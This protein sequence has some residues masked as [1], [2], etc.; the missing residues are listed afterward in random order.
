MSLKPSKYKNAKPFKAFIQQT[1]PT[2]YDDSLSYSELLYKVLYNMNLLV[3]N[4][5]LLISDI[6]KLYEYTND[7]FE[8]L[9]VQTE[10]DN[11]LEQMYTSGQLDELF[12]KYLD[13]EIDKINTAINDNFDE[14]N[15]K[16]AVLESRM[17]TFSSLP[18]GSTAGD[19]EL[20]DIRVGYDGTTYPNA[21]D[22]V[23]TQI[24]NL[25]NKF[26]PLNVVKNNFINTGW[27]NANNGGY[28]NTPTGFKSTDFI[29]IKDYKKIM[30]SNCCS[31]DIDGIAF[32]DETKNFIKGV[33]KTDFNGK[34]FLILDIEYYYY[35][36]KMGCKEENI[37]KQFLFLSYFDFNIDNVIENY[38]VDDIL[39]NSLKGIDNCS[40]WMDLNGITFKDGYIE[41]RQ[42]QS[43]VK[44]GVRTPELFAS[45]VSNFATIYYDLRNITGVYHIDFVYIKKSDNRAIHKTLKIIS[46]DESG[47]LS[48]D[49]SHYSVYND[50]DDSKPFFFLVVND[51]VSS[52]DVYTFKAKLNPFNGVNIAKENLTK[53]I[54]AI[55]NNLDT[56]ADKNEKMS[57]NGVLVSGS[58]KRFTPIISDN[59]IVQYVPVI[60]DN[61]LFIGNSLLLGFSTFGMCAKN[62]NHDY[63][64]Y[65]TEYIKD[66]NASLVSEKLAGNTFEGATSMSAVNNWYTSTLDAKL[67]DDIKLVVV[68][69]GDNV[70]TPETLNNFKISCEN[71]LTHIRTNCPN[72]RVC[73]VG[74][75][76]GSSEKQGI[77]N[78][79]CKQTGCVFIDISDLNTT[80]NQA[81]IGDVVDKGDGTQYIVDSAGIA[82]HPGN[83]GMRLI[84][85]RIL[86]QLD[87][88][89]N[90][91]AFD[92]SYDE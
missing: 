35:Y 49:L 44:N 41:Y 90:E 45:N 18:S 46:N 76:Y 4:N 10:I 19:A 40:Y 42:P 57:N 63:Y 20:Q 48:V 50:F 31:Y 56:K 53:T 62:S 8:N 33:K 21:G 83:K 34:S 79:A 88:S 87:I 59:G 17:D 84:A 71:L 91:V 67:N 54:I 37:D 12:K 66:I 70:N 25:E 22:A 9:N 15:D 26:I 16:I 51:G 55:Q 47:E 75:W 61:I 82:S 28:G 38:T 11:K 72:A 13:P 65:V 86:Y 92:E 1:L 60:P 6:Q 80:E 39:V 78:N 89:D 30:L 29:K 64:H 23:R 68:Q 7:Y 58:G 24:E 69:L 74:E 14:Q 85:N 3:E 73:W 77:I 2:I 81:K 32:Y 52:V 5:N 27:I 43:S 36:V